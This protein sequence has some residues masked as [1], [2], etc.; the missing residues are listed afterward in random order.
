MK[1]FLIYLSI[2]FSFVISSAGLAKPP[3]EQTIHGRIMDEQGNPINAEVQVWYHPLRPVV[4]EVSDSVYG[5]TDNLITMTYSGDDGYYGVE[6]P[7]DSVLVIITKGPE[8]ERKQKVFYFSETE[9]GGKLW[10]VRLKRLYNLQEMGWYGGDL[11]FHSLHSDGSQY[12]A[13]IAVAAQ[14]AGLSFAMLT[15][16]NGIEGK[17]EWLDTKTND[18]LP[19]LGNEIT[20]NTPKDHAE[21]GFGHMN[22][23]F[24]SRIDGNNI[25]T[26]YIWLRAVFEDHAAVQNMIDKT[27]DQ[28]GL[29][30]FNH[31]IQG[32]DWAGRFRSWGHV[33]N[34]DAIEIWN[35]WPIHINT[36]NDDFKKTNT[37]SYT[38]QC[39]FE[40]LNAGN[41]IAAYATSDCHDIYGK[42]AWPN[43]M[44][45]YRSTIGNGRTYVYCEQF[46]EDNLKKSLKEGKAFLTSGAGPLVILKV[47]GKIPGEIVHVPEDGKVC[48]MTNI[49][50]NYP[51]LDAPDAIRIIQDGKVVQNIATTGTMTQKTQTKVEVLKDGWVMVEV[52]GHWPMVT[53]TN[54]VY[55]DVAPYGDWD[56]PEW[57]DPP[58][59]KDFNAFEYKVQ[60][61]V[62][63][64]PSDRHNTT[65]PF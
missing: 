2:F 63:D 7:F 35:S 45:Y 47:D 57:N 49:L 41:R 19:I 65:Y 24:I 42:K 36:V 46:D 22:Q 1:W 4:K 62:P 15:D 37:N 9:N 13:E 8:W 56:N 10:N 27:H 64:G 43:E 61:S 17:Y 28:G 50:A 53:L 55:L 25:D 40:Y 3:I 12:P 33:K 16:H 38:T 60:M 6:V 21:S 52:F 58:N 23:I 30:F 20:T 59:I 39:W 14:G 54:P 31:P 51:L 29:I 48:V 32:S 34:F 5:V 26:S 44:V 11:H 18:F